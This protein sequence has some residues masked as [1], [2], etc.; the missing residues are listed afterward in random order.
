MSPKGI[1]DP[2]QKINEI[3]NGKIGITSNT[4]LRLEKHPGNSEGF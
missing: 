2:Y 3:V 1:R 4:A